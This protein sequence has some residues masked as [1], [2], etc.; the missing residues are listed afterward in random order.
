MKKFENV[1][2]PAIKK[3]YN[4]GFYQYLI[5]NAIS[6]FRDVNQWENELM[7]YLISLKEQLGVIN[8]WGGL[9][10]GGN[11]Y[12]RYDHILITDYSL[13]MPSFFRGLKDENGNFLL[14]EDHNILEDTEYIA[15][16]YQKYVKVS[17]D[18][19]ISI[20]Q[21]WILFLKGEWNADIFSV[22]VN[23]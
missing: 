21:L 16:H 4:Y 5:G 15:T 20:S 6:T 7:P 10:W 11:I 23:E 14:N 1:F 17:I 9:P 3:M 18:D 8:D 2:W 12:F 13:N 19:F 22:Q